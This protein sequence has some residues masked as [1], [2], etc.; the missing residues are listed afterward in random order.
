M[1]LVTS[2]EKTWGTQALTY[3][4]EQLTIGRALP[5]AYTGIEDDAHQVSR[6]SM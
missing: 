4:A 3:Y 2:V 5:R 6:L 1:G